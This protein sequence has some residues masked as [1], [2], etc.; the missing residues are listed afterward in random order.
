[1]HISNKFKIELI[2]CVEHKF[3]KIKNKFDRITFYFAVSVTGNVQNMKP[4]QILHWFS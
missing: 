1:M 4:G 2:F 3:L